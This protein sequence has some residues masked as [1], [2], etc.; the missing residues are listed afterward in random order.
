[1][2]NSYHEVGTSGHLAETKLTV[3]TGVVDFTVLTF[4]DPAEVNLIGAYMQTIG[5]N[6]V[7]RSIACLLP[8]GM[9]AQGESSIVTGVNSL[10]GIFPHTTFNE[11]VS[12]RSH[13]C[14]WT[15]KGLNSFTLDGI[16]GYFLAILIQGLGN[17]LGVVPGLHPIGE[18]FRRTTI[19]PAVASSTITE[20]LV[21][22]MVGIEH[23]LG[24]S[25]V[26][27]HIY[28]IESGLK[29]IWARIVNGLHRNLVCL[30]EIT[31]CL[32]GITTAFWISGDIVR[33][34]Q[35]PCVGQ[36]SL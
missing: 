18:V 5:T 11:V 22:I 17:H 23:N 34:L 31:V 8:V 3:S 19:S 25:I 14:P 7:R 6:H 21:L 2:V 15:T 13:T 26:G 33:I 24:V 10:H 29:F 35:P 36:V 20:F 16:D 30:L 4:R 27:C 1:M 12:D 9:V 28:I 32:T